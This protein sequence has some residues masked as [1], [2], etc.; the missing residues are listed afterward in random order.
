[1][2]PLSM[3]VGGAMKAGLLGMKGGGGGANH[4]DW[5]EASALGTLNRIPA[6]LR[7]KTGETT[8][9]NNPTRMNTKGLFLRKHFGA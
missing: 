9:E 6:P 5:K 7:L 4:R 3:K 8:N 1:M 2:K